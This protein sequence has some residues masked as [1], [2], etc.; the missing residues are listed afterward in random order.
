MRRRQETPNLNATTPAPRRAMISRPT[1]RAP[2]R[3]RAR[4]AVGVV[5]KSL[6]ASSTVNRHGPHA[7]TGTGSVAVLSPGAV[8]VSP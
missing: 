1:R 2:R 6:A 7:V 5:D 4:N 3:Q 8:L